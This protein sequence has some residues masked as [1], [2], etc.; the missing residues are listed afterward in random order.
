[1]TTRT[2]ETENLSYLIKLA[3]RTHPSITPAEREAMEAHENPDEDFPFIILPD[4][5]SG[6][7][8]GLKRAAD[9]L[10]NA[11]DLSEEA[12]EE[13]LGSVYQRDIADVRRVIQRVRQGIQSDTRPKFPARNN[14]L[15]A[16]AAQQSQKN[17]A[18]LKRCSPGALDT[19]AFDVIALLMREAE[20][21]DLLVC[22]GS[23]KN[24]F[25][26]KPLSAF[27][28]LAHECPFIVPQPMT[29]TQR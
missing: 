3:R 2:E 7:N 18:D 26:T 27:K 14:R 17:V 21:E 4:E 20:G 15:M 10:L 1:M 8:L 25:S 11:F 9:L 19:P 29:S 23:A 5:G 12:A 28:A 24:R 13:H 22:I 16:A 6:H